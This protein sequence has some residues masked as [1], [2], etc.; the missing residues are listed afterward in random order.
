MIHISNEYKKAIYGRSDWYPSARVTFLDGTVLNLGRSEFLISG[1]NIVDGAGTQSLPLGNVVSRKITVKL[2]NADDRYKI[3]SF[4]GAKISLYK[5]ISA[6]NGDLS[7]KSGTYTVIDPESYG[8]TVSFSAYDDAYKLD[9]DYT[10]H[11]KYPLKLSEILIDSCRT[12][13]VQLDTVHFNGEDITV[14]EAPTNTTHR[15]VVGLISMIAGGNA[16]MNADNHLQITDYDMTLFDGMTDLDGGWFDDPRQ[17]YDGGQFETDIITEKYVTYSDMTGGSFGDDIN[18]FFYDDLDW[19]KEK[20]ASGSD[21]D[22]GYFDDGLELLTNDSYGIMYRSVERK[23]RNPY[24]LI[25]KQY[26]GFRLRDGRTLGVHSVDTEE[27]SGYILSDAT[28]YYASGSNA[29]DGT[30]ELVDNFHF[31][32]QWKTGLTTGVENITITGIQTTDDENTYTYGTEGYILSIE[33]SLIEDKNLLVNTVGSKLVGLTFMNFSGEHLSYPLAE[34]MDLA[35]VI[36]RTGKTNRTIL[37]DIT[38][39]FLGFTQLKCSAENSVRNSSKYVNSETKAIQKSSAI[40]EKKIGKYDEAVQS[41]TA[42]MTQGMGFFKTEEIKEDKSVVFY[43]HNKERL[44]DSNIIW[45][46]VGD[47]FAVSTDGGK[48]WNAGLDSNGNAVVNVLSAVGINCDWIHSGTLT[49]GGYNNTN[50]HCA[51]ENADGKVVGT[52]GVN[53]YYSND[54]KDQYAIRV[55]NGQ[56]DV[57][58]SKGTLVGTVKYVQGAASE[59]IEMYVHSG[60][61]YS[62]VS[63]GTNGQTAIWGDSVLVATDKLITGGAQAKTGRAVFSDGSYLDYRNGYLIGGRTAS[64]TTF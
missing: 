27:A 39:N 30:F 35:Y 54:P 46:M 16:W 15:Q 21:M 2:Y 53:G 64:G 36:D 41:L 11:L 26:D 51:I 19:N 7:I 29:D 40:T 3:H 28:A 14:K 4:L 22:G 37:T 44:E 55:N 5:T 57:Y 50:G 12:C 59:G 9:R 10:T 61:H 43:L 1:N 33:N 42:L 34:F 6:E 13:G 25:S 20:Y 60:N 47:A 62:A 31:L 32:T 18:E 52:L 48:T 58:G 63:V 17:N 45:K 24:H 38:F 56:I 49:L 23:Q 8:D